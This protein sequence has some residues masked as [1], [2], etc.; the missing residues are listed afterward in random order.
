MARYH[1]RD[2]AREDLRRASLLFEET[3]AGWSRLEGCKLER[4][5]TVDLVSDLKGIPKQFG[6]AVALKSDSARPRTS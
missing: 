6:R 5:Q 1:S 3:P 4:V 2:P